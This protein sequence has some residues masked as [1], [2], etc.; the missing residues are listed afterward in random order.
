M[1][2]FDTTIQHRSDAFVREAAEADVVETVRSA[3]AE[4]M[5][6]RLRATDSA[7]SHPS[8]HRG[9]PT[10]LVRQIGFA[11]GPRLATFA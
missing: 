10:G 5:P 3:R 11:H 4:G 7:P 2:A 1:D 8:G 6:L 9:R